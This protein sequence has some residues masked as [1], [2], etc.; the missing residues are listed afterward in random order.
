[1]VIRRSRDCLTKK[2][3]RHPLL[4]PH[5]YE[6]SFCELVDIISLNQNERAGWGQLIIIISKS[7]TT[8]IHR[9]LPHLVHCCR[10]FGQKLMS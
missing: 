3:H 9:P 1:M 10:P 7:S 4:R 8:W 2:I 5:S 6:Y